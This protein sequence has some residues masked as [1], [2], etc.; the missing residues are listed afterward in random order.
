MAALKPYYSE[1]NNAAK[2]RND[3]IEDSEEDN[4]LEK[5]HFAGLVKD[6]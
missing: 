2:L 6:A 1:P 3:N 5:I 4:H